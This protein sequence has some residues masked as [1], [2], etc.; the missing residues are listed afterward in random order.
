[1]LAVALIALL[2]HWRVQMLVRQKNVLELAVLQRTRELEQEKAELLHAR[3]QMRHFA[4]SD[5]LTNLLNHRVILDRLRGEVE[6]S[7]R[8]NMPLSILMIDLDHFKSIND[9]YGHM[10][11]DHVLK[12]VSAILQRA[13][14]SYDWVGRYGGEEFLLILPGSSF[15]AAQVRAEQL[16]LAIKSATIVDG[17]RAIHV[18]ASFG[19][20]AGFPIAPDSVIRTADQALYRAKASGRDCVIAS[21]IVSSE[22]PESE[23]SPPL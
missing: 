7:R 6:R 23:E 17:D 4:E 16:R 3:E 2:W 14:R 10:A 8:E 9:T 13:I 22:S 12:V 15:N 5:G 21:K 18:T 11:G 20:A 1:V 19:V